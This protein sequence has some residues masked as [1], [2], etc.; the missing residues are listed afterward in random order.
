MPWPS[1]PIVTAASPVRT[2]ARARRSGAPT[3]SPSAETAAT[4][5]SAARTARSASSSSRRRPPHRHHRVADELLDRPAV[6]PDQPAARVEV[7]RQK[8]AHLLGVARLGE[9]REPDQVGESTETSRRSAAGRLSAPRDGACTAAASGGPHSPQNFAARLVRRAARRAGAA[10]ARAALAAELA[11]GLVLAAAARADGHVQSLRL[12]NEI[13]NAP[14]L[15][16]MDDR[17]GGGAHVRHAEP[18]AA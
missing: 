3:S 10:Q 9:R 17:R 7:A 8:L 13:L 14:D 12:D 11:V 4:R 18:F 16:E 15:G 5:S 6:E 2:P 1:A